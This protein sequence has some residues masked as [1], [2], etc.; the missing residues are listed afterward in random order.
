MLDVITFVPKPLLQ[1]EA[2][3]F[4]GGEQQASHIMSWMKALGGASEWREADPGNHIRCGLKEHIRIIL[5][6]AYMF[7]YVGD[8]IIRD[9]EGVF[10]ALSR[11]SADIK[12]DRVIVASSI[13][14]LRPIS[15]F[16]EP[17]AA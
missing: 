5:G 16:D 9:E 6:S 15:E 11:R 12:Y 10:K 2:V 8:Y 7:V 13:T 14:Q 17:L 3:E 1:I 4:T